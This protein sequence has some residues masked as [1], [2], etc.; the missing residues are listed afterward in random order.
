MRKMGAEVFL[1]CRRLESVTFSGDAPEFFA[2]DEC[3]GA[4]IYRGTSPSLVTFV[5][6]G[7]KDW[8]DGADGLPR[9]WPAEG[10]ESARQIRYGK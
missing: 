4:D 8:Q 3:R 7:S 2:M 10:G 9:K 1:D 5:P 6:K